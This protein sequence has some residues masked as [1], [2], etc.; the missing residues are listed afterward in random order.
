[1]VLMDV[2]EE[3][4]KMAEDPNTPQHLRLGA[5]KQLVALMGVAGDSGAKGAGPVVVMP[6]RADGLPPDPLL[7]AFPVTLDEHGHAL[8]ADPM[9]DLDCARVVKRMPHALYA[10]VL[11]V[12]PTDDKQILIDAEQRFLREARNRGF[13][14]E[15]DEPQPRRQTHMTKEQRDRLA[16]I[17]ERISTVR[18]ERA[19]ARQTVSAAEQL[20]DTEAVGLAQAKLDATEADLAHLMGL[21]NAALSH[22]V[23]GAMDRFGGTLANNLDAQRALA[24]IASSSAPLRG[25]V[26]IGGFM[27]VDGVLGLTGGALRATPVDVPDRGG[28]AGFLGIAPTHGARGNRAH[29][30]HGVDAA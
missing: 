10:K 16:A 30:D 29:A 2:E 18:G 28:R 26:A 19:R 3:L 6:Q 17:R 5:V 9:A 11:Q 8:P 23:H 21:E 24:E 15:A 4:R 27:S 13:D 25:N 14:T 7:D 12:V 20:K 22:A 1:M